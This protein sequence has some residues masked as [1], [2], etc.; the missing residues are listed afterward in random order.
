MVM[1]P[2]TSAGMHGIGETTHRLVEGSKVMGVFMD[3]KEMN[4]PIV[5]GVIQGVTDAVQSA[6]TS[7]LSLDRD[8][9]TRDLSHG[10][11]DPR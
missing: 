8:A 10:F 4:S 2:V 6:N 1:M 3:G 11:C 9:P 7:H 5:M